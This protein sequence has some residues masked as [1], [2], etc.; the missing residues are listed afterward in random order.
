MGVNVVSVI[1]SG[2]CLAANFGEASPFQKSTEKCGFEGRRRPR[3]LVM[4]NGVVVKINLK[5][6][7]DAVSKHQLSVDELGTNRYRMLA[8]KLFIDN[9]LG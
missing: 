6:L 5:N 2:P 7:K 3:E 4:R 1:A 9:Q 8:L